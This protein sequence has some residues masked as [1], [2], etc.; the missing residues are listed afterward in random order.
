MGA[1]DKLGLLAVLLFKNVATS[2]V[3]RRAGKPPLTPEVIFFGDFLV[4]ISLKIAK[5]WK[6]KNLWIRIHAKNEKHETRG[7]VEWTNSRTEGRTDTVIS[8][9]KEKR[10]VHSRDARGRDI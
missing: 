9:E 7:S 2:S 5:S 8:S 10:L 6:F 3:V 4:L 1:R